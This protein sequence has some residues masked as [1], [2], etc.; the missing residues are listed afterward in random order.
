VAGLKPIESDV[1]G[2]IHV[3]H[4]SVRG[5]S[6]VEII[7]LNRPL[8][9]MTIHPVDSYPIIAVSASFAGIEGHALAVA[10]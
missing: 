8:W 2:Y 9:V 3:P 4:F 5:F 6:G 7:H 10:R 1:H